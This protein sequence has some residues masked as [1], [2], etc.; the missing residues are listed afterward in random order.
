M[1]RTH[2]EENYPYLSRTR[3]FKRLK[4]HYSKET[5]TEFETAIR[6][7]EE[8]ENPE[9]YEEARIEPIISWYEGL[10][11]TNDLYDCYEGITP[12]KKEAFTIESEQLEELRI[13][14]STLKQNAEKRVEQLNVTGERYY[15][16]CDDPKIQYW[17][18]SGDA[19]RVIEGHIIALLKSKE[20]WTRNDHTIWE[21]CGQ[22][23]TDD[24]TRIICPKC[25]RKVNVSREDGDI[26]GITHC[27][28]KTNG[29]P[30]TFKFVE[31]G[32]LVY[33]NEKNITIE[34]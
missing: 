18:G 6:K 34:L 23:Q 3:D 24:S 4:E 20:A 2:N 8:T 31:G 16:D 14:V 22:F 11:N 5:L 15:G 13:I 32:G 12:Y 7:Y 17:R 19:Y 10:L 30:T 33:T 9:D 21:T 28:C 26:R 29:K 1:K 25:G 27:K